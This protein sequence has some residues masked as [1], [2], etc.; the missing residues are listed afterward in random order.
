MV[1]VRTYLIVDYTRQEQ[2]SFSKVYLLL[3]EL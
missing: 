1:C 2:K 3:V